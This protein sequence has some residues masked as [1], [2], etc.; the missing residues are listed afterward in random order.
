MLLVDDHEAIIWGLERL[1]EKEPGMRVV[2]KAGNHDEARAAF[3]RVVPDVI[4]LD[5]DLDGRSSL[6]LMPEFLKHSG[7]KIL[8]STGLRDAAEEK[9]AMLRGARGIIRKGDPVES[10]VRAIACVHEGELWLNRAATAN[11]IEELVLRK[12]DD[13]EARRIATLTARERKVVEALTSNESGMPS[14]EIATQLNM[15]ES[16]LRNHL[17][18]IYCKLE[19]SNRLGLV[20]YATKHRL[21]RFPDATR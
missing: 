21:T 2:G 17:T 4:L 6:D 19:V 7:V 1:I 18:S 12:R 10:I 13:P 8:V 15:S 11:L 16:T 9:R 14:K 3:S 5:L 20:L